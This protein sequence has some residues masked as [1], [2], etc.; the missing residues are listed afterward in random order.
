[1]KLFLQEISIANVRLCSKH[2]SGF[3]R[4]FSSIA[5]LFENFE[6][7]AA[8]IGI[9]FNWVKQSIFEFAEKNEKEKSI[10]INIYK[11]MIK[12]T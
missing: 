9:G 12:C 3:C 5:A 7:K 2:L 6:S 4:F 11:L 8:Y 10:K 1:M